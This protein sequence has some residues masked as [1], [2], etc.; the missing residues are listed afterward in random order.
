[1]ESRQARWER[2]RR[3]VDR[4]HRSEESSTTFARANGIST[5]TLFAWQRRVAEWAKETASHR[6]RSSELT[7][8]PVQIVPPVVNEAGGIDLLLVSGDRLH[9][10]HDAPEETVRMVVR[11]LRATC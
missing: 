3:V 2:M 5:T 10:G 9:V 6:G 8:V 1:M 7:L 11:V 4:W